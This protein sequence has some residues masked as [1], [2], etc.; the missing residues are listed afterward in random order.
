MG[1]VLYADQVTLLQ[2]LLNTKIL[3]TNH[4][5]NPRQDKF[6]I[7]K[8]LFNT[9]MTLSEFSRREVK[10]PADQNIHPINFIL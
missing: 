9:G 2:I 5:R 1:K 3:K 7:E 4:F 6:R 8:A 10:Y